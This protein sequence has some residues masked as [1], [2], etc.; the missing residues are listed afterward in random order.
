VGKPGI[1]GRRAAGGARWVGAAALVLLAGAA[2]SDEAREPPLGTRAACA[3]YG[4]LPAEWG[5]R[6]T[7][8]MVWIAGGT[9]VPGTRAGY[10]EE[11]PAG[12][13][14][15]DG[16]WID[17]TEVT[18]AQFA[19][20]VAHT[21]YVTT[22]ERGGGAPV[23][24]IPRRAEL[25]LREYAWWQQ[26]P[27]ASWRHPEGPASDLRGRA[28]HPVVQVT[29]ADAQAYARWLGRALPAEAEWEL[30]ARAGRD[31][32]QLQRAP[33]DDR[34][35]PLANF[36]QG[37]FPVRNSAED[38]FTLAAPVGCFPANPY[39]L[40]DTIG[41]VW[42]WTD[43]LYQAARTPG[44][45]ACSQHTAGAGARV[46]KGG[47]FLCSSDFC[48]RYRVTARHPQEPDVPAMHVGF[49]TMRR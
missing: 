3:A 32:A 42:E 39:G 2:R 37:E 26:V 43:D 38:G 4:G 24:H 22:A 15:V 8:G 27:G 6:A 20:F 35:R 33:R 23:F 9:F 48:A 10:P 18:N 31:E 1:Q 16:F 12:P 25:G 44:D 49:R 17:R 34:G 19:D 7:A 28:H 11:R 29:H 45:V 41:N 47:S 5:R 30:A 14:H 13:V 46:I 36:W 21:G 40:F